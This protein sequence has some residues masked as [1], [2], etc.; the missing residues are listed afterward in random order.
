MTDDQKREIV[1]RV[2]WKMFCGD[3]VGLKLQFAQNWWKNNPEPMKRH[4]ASV[5]N[6]LQA[7]DYFELREAAEKAQDTLEDAYQVVNNLMPLGE[8]DGLIDKIERAQMAYK[9]AL[10]G[11]GE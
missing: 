5:E 2:A 8:Y 11:G 1:E 3:A 9:D 4:S 10:K 7:A 6:V